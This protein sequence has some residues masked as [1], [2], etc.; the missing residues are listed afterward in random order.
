MPKINR[1]TKSNMLVYVG[2]NVGHI[3]GMKVSGSET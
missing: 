1:Q 3:D 2:A